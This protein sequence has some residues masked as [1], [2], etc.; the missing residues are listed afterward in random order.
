MFLCCFSME[1]TGPS[2]QVVVYTAYRYIQVLPSR[3]KIPS[4]K[5]YIVFGI[6]LP[7]MA[8]HHL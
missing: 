1:S 5:V 6:C 4:T 2:F 7:A 3:C 8:R